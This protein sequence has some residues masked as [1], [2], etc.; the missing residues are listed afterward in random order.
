MTRTRVPAIEGWFTLDDEPHLLGTR[1]SQSGTY[2]F[3][4]ETTMSR[5]PG[6]AD[7]MLESVQLSRTGTIWL[8]TRTSWMS[9]DGRRWVRVARLIISHSAP[10]ARQLSSW[11]EPPPIA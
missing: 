9:N 4:P 1:C 6:Y 8:P 5:A 3:P 10:A 2:Y 11:A 7:S